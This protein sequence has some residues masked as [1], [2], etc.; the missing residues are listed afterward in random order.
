[1]DEGKAR[2][3][4]TFDGEWVGELAKDGR[5]LRKRTSKKRPLYPTPPAKVKKPADLPARAPLPPQNA[6]IGYDMIDVLEDDPE[7][8]KRVSDRRSDMD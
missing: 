4:Y 6:E 5:I 2:S 7:V 8:F 1:V 3:A